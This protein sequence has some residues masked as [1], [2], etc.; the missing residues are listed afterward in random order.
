MSKK[1]TMG[2]QP[3]IT[4]DPN[5]RT[6]IAANKPRVSL[7]PPPQMPSVTRTAKPELSVCCNNDQTIIS[8]R[9]SEPIKD[10]IGFAVYRKLNNE[11]EAEAEPL[12]N[13]IGFAD[14]QFVKGE[15]RPS[16]EW[17]IQRFMWTDFSVS[18]GDTVAY[19]IVPMLYNGT[20]L[21][22]D[23]KNASDWSASVKIV[24]G[25][26]ED[27][28]PS[29]YSAY[30]NRGIIAS[31]FFSRMRHDL[32]GELPGQSMK[33]I[34]G[35]P[36][37]KLRDFLG[38]FLDNKLFALLDEIIKDSSL[39]VFG[40]LYE[41]HQ[42][43]LIEKLNKIS[44]RAHIILANGAA[45]SKTEDKNVD[46]RSEIKN[47]GVEVFDRI[48][49]PTQ[50]HF[51]HNKFLVI[52]KDGKPERVWT[53]STN[54]TPG[55]MFAQ[56]NNAL[57]IDDS[58]LAKIYLKEWEKL[59]EDTEKN[60]SDYGD[61]LYSANAAANA[62]GHKNSKVWFS[63]TPDYGDLRDVESI[64]ENAKDG[65]LFLM[66]NPGPQN[67]F[68]N[69][70]QDLQSRKP[71]LFIHGVINQDPG[72]KNPLLFFHKGAKVETDWDAILPKKVDEE[73]SFWYKEISAGLVTIHSKVLVIDPF[74][75]NP[76]VVT[77]S[78]NF[79]PKASFSNDEN[80]IV[81]N[82]KRIAEEYAV[83]I[84]AVYDH[85]RWRYSLFQENTDY[86]GLTKERDWMSGYMTGGVRMKELN[87]WI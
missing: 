49:D 20:S 24:T 87:F 84:M 5:V 38:G 51:A 6:S 27:N 44:S 18:E 53:G 23:M 60:D 41:L 37:N 25:I 30:F 31:Q 66:F 15:Q 3:G 58:A 55:G 12:K 14:E 10:C 39:T 61:K 7:V 43:D 36:Q 80:L 17:P 8:W 26:T 40:A 56:V 2:T 73:F 35:G 57:L 52:C 28:K 13:R 33:A 65:I 16:T 69:Y 74:G 47:N 86:K 1:T 71:D 19:R 42:E 11:N 82:D 64:M 59:K 63:P 4:G 79:G 67:T 22:K 78:H 62:F 68:F 70:I 85:Y 29:P 72:T 9:Y 46:S 50:K 48:V 32:A 54:W 81:I 21:E 77:G 75:D 45:K 83:N 34:I 76:Y